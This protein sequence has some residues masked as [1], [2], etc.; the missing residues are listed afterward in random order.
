M[1]VP[2]DRNTFESIKIVFKLTFNQ[3]NK[4]LKSGR[5]IIEL[6]VYFLGIQVNIL[7]YHH[8]NFSILEILL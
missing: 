2:K 3:A 7:K 8:A 6:S 1:S 4:T 5:I